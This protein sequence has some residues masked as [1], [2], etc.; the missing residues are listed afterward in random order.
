MTNAYLK[1]LGFAGVLAAIAV[2]LLVYITSYIGLI[3][4]SDFFA[5][6]ASGYEAAGAI[7]FV[8]G[9]VVQ[10]VIERFQFKKNAIIV[11]G[12]ICAFLF[13]IFAAVFAGLGIIPTTA[14]ILTANGNYLGLALGFITGALVQAL[15]KNYA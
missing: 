2:M 5:V 9:V 6:S 10:G 12:V 13:L 4:P 3:P 11:A 7:G 1:R 14:Y 15:V 8:I